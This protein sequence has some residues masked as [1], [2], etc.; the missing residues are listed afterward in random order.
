MLP[1]NLLE[2]KSNNCRFFRLPNP[3]GILP[4]ILLLERKSVVNPV[5]LPIPSGILP[6]MSLELKSSIDNLGEGFPM[7]LD[8]DP[9]KWFHDRSRNLKIEQLESTS[10]THIVTQCPLD[11]LL[12]ARFSLCRAVS[13]HNS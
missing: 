6:V 10:N 8:K 5:R 13:F 4:V 7:P 2:L 9:L 1:C 3:L 11:R 12:D